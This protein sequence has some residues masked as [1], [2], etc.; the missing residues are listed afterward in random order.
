MGRIITAFGQGG[1]VCARHGCQKR[2]VAPMALG[3]PNGEQR[4]EFC[5][6]HFQDAAGRIDAH[7]A[8][9]KELFAAILSGN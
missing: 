6:E 3:G 5:S 7:N 8:K 9:A 4:V 2:A 1:G